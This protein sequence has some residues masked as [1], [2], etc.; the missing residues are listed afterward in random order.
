VNP[1]DDFEL[2]LADWLEE[3]PFVAPNRPV[4]AAIEHARAHPRRRFLRS[5][6][7]R[8]AMDS[9][10]VTPLAPRHSNN[11]GRVLAAGLAAV[12]V[13]AVAVVSGSVLLGGGGH[14]AVPGGVVAPGASWTPAP[15]ST[16]A[17]SP[18]PVAVTGTN[19]VGTADAGTDTTVGDVE[20]IRAMVLS[21]PTTNS[22]PRVSGLATV[23]V[24]I[25]IQPGQSAVLWGTATIEG[26]DGAWTGPFTGLIEKGYTIHRI[27]SV[28]K[29]TGA[30]AGLQYRYTQTS[31]DGGTFDSSGVI[32]SIPASEP[33]ESITAPI[34]ISGSEQCGS[35]LLG[36]Y[37]TSTRAGDVLQ[38]RNGTVSCYEFASDDRASGSSTRTINQD[39]RP[40]GS[41][42][43]WG[44]FEI[45]NAGG[46]W[47]GAWTG[48]VDSKANVSIVGAA[49]G[50]GGYAGLQYRLGATMAGDAAEFTVTGSISPV[51]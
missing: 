32:E 39:E 33:G 34:G 29:G 8:S 16:P 4:S 24:N 51:A 35:I 17:P 47:T 2:R 43:W 49:I 9:T 14:E 15:Q 7:W 42:T 3:G 36:T 37:G 11:T 38:T 21:G 19:T 12:V 40:D 27:A 31:T 20:Q 30:Y 6:P 28:L 5:A 25:D 48:T 13:V 26:P 45:E 41:A 1:E 44:T 50:S 10:H 18:S 22:D 23:H 46:T